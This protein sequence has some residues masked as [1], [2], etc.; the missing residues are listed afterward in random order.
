[1]ILKTTKI[2]DLCKLE[3]IRIYYIAINYKIW[4]WVLDKEMKF[5]ELDCTVID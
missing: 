5:A 2:Y 1:M 3:V 4:S